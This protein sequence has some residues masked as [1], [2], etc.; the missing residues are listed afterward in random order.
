MPT[1]PVNRGKADR[2]S[3]QQALSEECESA[4]S[5]AGDWM[6]NGGEFG[7]GRFRKETP[8]S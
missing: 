2:G 7:K 3:V 4:V 8:T 1:I 5:D 6:Y